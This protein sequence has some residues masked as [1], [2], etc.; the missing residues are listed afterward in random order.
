MIEKHFEI[1]LKK[2]NKTLDEPYVKYNKDLELIP[3]SW[4]E[5][6]ILLND[7]AES[8]ELGRPY[9]NGECL[10]S[11]VKAERYQRGLV[12]SLENMWTEERLELQAERLMLR[13]DRRRL[14]SMI[15]DKAKKDTFESLISEISANLNDRISLSTPKNKVYVGE[16]SGILIIS[17]WHFGAKVDNFLNVFNKEVFIERINK[18]VAEVVLEIHKHKLEKLYIANLNDLISGIIHQN[19]RLQNSEDIIEQIMYVADT[20]IQMIQEFSKYTHV[21]YHD[22]LDNHSR[23]VPDKKL[24]ISKENFAILL[25]WLLKKSFAGNSRVTIVDNKYDNAIIT[26]S[27]YNWKY[28]GV[29][30]HQDTINSVVSD[31]SL[32]TKEF[33]DVMFLGHRHHFSANEIHGTTVYAN[34]S[35]SGVDELAKD[36]RL[37]SKPSQTLIIVSPYDYAEY[38]KTIKF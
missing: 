24:A 10:R 1:G 27:V 35:L 36:L 13:D 6:A 38:V 20:L 15:K 2:I 17:D 34:G 25:P 12:K 9:K 8:M 37:T 23:V 4:D 26:F 18:L 22:C 16:R 21:E 5:L 7:D 28:L 3:L 32:M 14:Q 31:L 19:L 30:G 33:Y 29:H 11:D